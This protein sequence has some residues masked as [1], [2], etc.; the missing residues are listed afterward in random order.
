MESSYTQLQVSHWLKKD[1]SL[2]FQM[3]AGRS[4]KIW[5]SE[6]EIPGLRHF[7]SVHVFDT[8]KLS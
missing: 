6:P 2:G 8:S 5:K 7:T 4:A 1:L 3:E